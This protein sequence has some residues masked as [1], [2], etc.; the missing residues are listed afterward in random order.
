M[1]NRSTIRISLQEV[2]TR[3]SIART[4]VA[5]FHDWL[6]HLTEPVED[7]LLDSLILITEIRRLDARVSY[8]ETALSNLTAAGRAA[9]AAHSDGEDDH[10]WYLRDELDHQTNLASIVHRE[11][12]DQGHA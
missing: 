12:D 4:I 6:G 2:T 11:R 10:L 8:A 7:A 3:N 9:L 1:T 5:A